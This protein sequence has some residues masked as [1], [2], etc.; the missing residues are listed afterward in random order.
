MQNMTP[1]RILY[2]PYI[3]IPD[4]LWTSRALLY[5]DNIGVIVPE[6]YIYHPEK[7]NPRM[8]DLVTS[9]LVEQIIPRKFTEKLNDFKKGF[10]D[11]ILSPK[12]A[13]NERRQDFV[14]GKHF[15]IH[16]EKFDNGL[17]SILV[18]LGLAKWG[19]WP[20]WSVEAETATMLM[21]YLATIISVL[22]DRGPVTDEINISPKK[23][24]SRAITNSIDEKMMLRNRLLNDILPLPTKIE[25]DDLVKIKSSY[26]KDL[27]RFRNNIEKIILDLSLFKDTKDFENRYKLQ[28][29]EI[30]DTKEFI[31][32]KLKGPNFGKVVF[33]TIC[34]LTATGIAVAQTPQEQLYWTIPS[35]LTAVYT[36][37]DSHKKSD[38]RHQQP[39][40]YLALIDKQLKY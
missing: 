20:W 7:L 23:R 31:T 37:I 14:K 12:F 24:F 17:M 1:N 10:L 9:Q 21:T 25:I 34:S 3:N 35:I 40:S 19:D 6:D 16:V 13:I 2:Y 33:G 39:L 32:D 27:L 18:E 28:L 11:I 36:A 26:S 38:I 15:N 8:L 22:D 30:R 29:A 5:W 4:T